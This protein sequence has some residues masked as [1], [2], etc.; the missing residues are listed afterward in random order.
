MPRARGPPAP[1]RRCNRGRDIRAVAAIV[2]A[3]A[4]S[5]SRPS[6]HC[7][8]A[9]TS[10]G[11]IGTGSGNGTRPCSC[12]SERYEQA[13]SIAAG[14]PPVARQSSASTDDSGA[15]PMRRVRYSADWSMVRGRNRCVGNEVWKDKVEPSGS[16]RQVTTKIAV[17][18]SS[19]SSTALAMR[20]AKGCCASEQFSRTSSTGAPVRRPVARMALATDRRS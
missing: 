20:S 10:S 9:S 17:A 18:P 4:V 15:A 6:T 12:S 5:P 3:V 16:S 8:Y 14:L 1:A 7:P 13:E 11:P 19:G 2:V